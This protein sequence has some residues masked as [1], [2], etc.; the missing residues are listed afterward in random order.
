MPSYSSDL[1]YPLWEVRMAPRGQGFTSNGAFNVYVRAPSTYQAQQYALR[2][3]PGCVVIDQ[4]RIRKIKEA[5][6]P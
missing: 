4:N 3:N 2:E 1:Q 5:R 6:E